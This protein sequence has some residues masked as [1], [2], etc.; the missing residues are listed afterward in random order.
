MHFLLAR[1]LM[2]E[3]DSEERFDALLNALKEKSVGIILSVIIQLE[4]TEFAVRIFHDN[5]EKFGEG[6][7]V[8]IA[9]LNIGTAYYLLNTPEV[10]ISRRALFQILFNHGALTYRYFESHPL[11]FSGKENISYRIRLACQHERLWKDHF[12]DWIT[13]LSKA[14]LIELSKTVKTLEQA[15]TLV[16]LLHAKGAHQALGSMAARFEE[17][18]Q[19][20][21][22][23]TAPS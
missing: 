18:E 14:W 21:V 16:P 17:K 11:L 1:Q 8:T 19:T 6:D 9:S 7:I 4:S 15:H 13:P 22:V 23:Y 20:E 10:K 12:D 5:Q 2:A 3:P